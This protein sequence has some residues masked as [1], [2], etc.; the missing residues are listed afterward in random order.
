ML[1]LVFSKTKVMRESRF[2]SKYIKELSSF[3]EKVPSLKFIA[4]PYRVFTEN[5]IYFP[6]KCSFN[7]FMPTGAFNIC[8]PTDCVSRHNG[9]TSGTSDSKC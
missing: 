8:C 1:K 7:P 9:D 4:D 3:I 2:V 5:F 6:N